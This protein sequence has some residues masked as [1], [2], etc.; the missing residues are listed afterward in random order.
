MIGSGRGGGGGFNSF[1]YR[2]SHQ[3][4][5]DGPN[6]GRGRGRTGR[7]SNQNHR[8]PRQPKGDNSF[9]AQLDI[10]V[11]QRKLLVGK[12]GETLNWL[13]EASGAKIF[14]PRQNRR[15][16]QHQ[17]EVQDNDANNNT[18]VISQHQQQQYPVRVNSS[19]V[20]SL[21]HAFYEIV[22]LLSRSSDFSV[23]SIG[24][25]VQ[26]RTNNDNTNVNGELFF[27][28]NESRCLFSGTV[29]ASQI[30]FQVYCIESIALDENGVATVVDNVRFVHSSVDR[31]RWISRKLSRRNNTHSLEGL[32]S[33]EIRHL[34]FVYG[35]DDDNPT[36]LYEEICKAINASEN[37]ITSTS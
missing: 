4:G 24:C 1:P 37:I 32:E 36:L 10:P 16:N 15:Q 3:Q 17:N 13:K 22:H 19:N 18:A 7:N 33:E 30:K 2:S 6:R 25:T 31:C 26:M 29:D 23:N 28:E 27:S 14:I 11:Q 21:L 12:G 34:V 35:T 8:R 20:A 5:Q 9:Q